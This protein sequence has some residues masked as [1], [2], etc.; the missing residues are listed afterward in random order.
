[1]LRRRDARLPFEVQTAGDITSLHE[2]HATPPRRGER[3]CEKVE[4][5]SECR[6]EFWG[7]HDK[8][9]KKR[10]KKK[11]EKKNLEA[12]SQGR[13]PLRDIGDSRNSLAQEPWTCENE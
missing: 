10:K 6:T 12:N 3:W 2:K 8:K 7:S 11:T 13:V 1:M 9:K 5:H 4:L